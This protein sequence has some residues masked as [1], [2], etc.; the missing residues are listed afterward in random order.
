MGIPLSLSMS[1]FLFNPIVEM[2]HDFP[3]VSDLGVSGSGLIAPFC[4]ASSGRER[5]SEA[6]PLRPK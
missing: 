5:A 1:V 2:I 3:E 6:C 4:R